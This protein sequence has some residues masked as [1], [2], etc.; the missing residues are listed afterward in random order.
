MTG[1]DPFPTVGE[2]ATQ[3]AHGDEHALRLVY[4]KWGRLVFTVALRSLGSSA[5]AEDVTQQVFIA[6]WRSRDTLR[7]SDTA[8]PAWLMGIA[9]FKIID[10]LRA[11]SRTERA[12]E[13]VPEDSGTPDHVNDLTDRI[14]VG[15][16]LASLGDPRATILREVFMHDKTHQETAEKLGLPLGTVKSHVRRGLAAMRDILEEVDHVPVG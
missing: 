10:A 5:D 1:P 12:S 4:E 8:L 16:A 14:V 13:S 9:R 2:L 11:R 15:Q 3:L 7:P 6:A